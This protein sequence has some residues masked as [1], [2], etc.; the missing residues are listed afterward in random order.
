MALYSHNRT[1]F[2]IPVADNT[3]IAKDTKEMIYA[4]FEHG[5]LKISIVKSDY[6]A[7]G[8]RLAVRYVIW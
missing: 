7:V 2:N 3:E 6:S 5:P 1:C 4:L 8:S